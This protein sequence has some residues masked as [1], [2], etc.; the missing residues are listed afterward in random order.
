MTEATRRYLIR[1]ALAWL[2][3]PVL[4]IA[5]AA[6]RELIVHPW[7]G[8]AL[9]QPLSGVTLIAILAVYAGLVFRAAVMGDGADA[10]WLLGLLWAGLTLIFEYALIAASQ[11]APLAKLAYTLSP[12]AIHDGNLFVLAL[13]FVLIAPR[14]FWRPAPVDR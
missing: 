5:N 7:L 12:A 14:L 10:A 13:I 4:A 9:A 11:E 6:L 8:E 1:G 3:M 2:P